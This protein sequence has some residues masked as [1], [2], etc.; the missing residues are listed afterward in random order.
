MDELH[1][2]LCCCRESFDSTSDDSVNDADQQNELGQSEHPTGK[3]DIQTQLDVPAEEVLLLP[4]GHPE[5]PT[6]NQ[7]QSDPV[8]HK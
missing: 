8:L 2:S 1:R 4:E 5:L 7:H 3:Q 6:T